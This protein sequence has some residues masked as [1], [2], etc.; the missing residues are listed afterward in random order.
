[1]QYKSLQTCKLQI[2][3]IVNPVSRNKTN[4][5]S[6]YKS[7]SITAYSH[8]MWFCVRYMTLQNMESRHRSLM[9]QKLPVYCL[10]NNKNN[11]TSFRLYTPFQLSF[12]GTIKQEQNIFLSISNFQIFFFPNVFLGYSTLNSICE[13]AFNK[14][15]LFN[16]TILFQLIKQVF[17]QIDVK[18]D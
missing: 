13:I 12:K 6:R 1:M 17:Y 9:I 8:G 10:D 5:Y 15:S 7:Y 18:K 11:V 14:I 3:P 4:V 16:T 2:V